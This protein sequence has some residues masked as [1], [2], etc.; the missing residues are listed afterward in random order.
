LKRD[1]LTTFAL[2]TFVQPI[3]ASNLHDVI[4][5]IQIFDQT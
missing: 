3:N 1:R 4:L 5:N 2:G